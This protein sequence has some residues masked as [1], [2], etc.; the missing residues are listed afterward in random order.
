MPSGKALSAILSNKETEML[1]E[2]VSR[3]KPTVGLIRRLGAAAIALVV[4]GGCAFNDK[5]PSMNQEAAM[6]GVNSHERFP[7]LVTP[8]KEE[9]EIVA[10]SNFFALAREDKERVL[11]LVSEYRQR[12]HGKILIVVPTGTANA[13]ASIGAAAQITQAMIDRGIPGKEIGVVA[14][15]P[16]AGNDN[17]PLFLRFKAWEAVAAP[18]GRWN[19]NLAGSV[20]NAPGSNFGCTAR[21]NLAAMLADPYDLVAP[22]QL[23]SGDPARRA[24]VFDKYRSGEATS[25]QRSADESGKASEVS[26]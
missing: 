15:E 22:Q 23:D 17:A 26:Q 21:A 11:N 18:C 2:N 9:I 24:A 7:I 16:D 10:S 1:V 19:Q 13:P 25:T 14:Y 5:I 6:S 8:K 12:G 3:K 20:M 4:L